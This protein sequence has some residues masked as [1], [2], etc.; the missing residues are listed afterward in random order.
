MISKIKDCK[1]FIE[2]DRVFTR[3]IYDVETEYGCYDIIIPKIPLN[4]KHDPRFIFK[5]YDTTLNLSLKEVTD[6]LTGNSDFSI[7]PKLISMILFTEKTKKNGVHQDANG[8]TLYIARKNNKRHRM[9]TK[10]IEKELGYMIEI[11]G[12]EEND[13]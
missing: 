1:T 3:L 7:P 5:N 4:F 9:T 11:V 12:E 6:R 2:N 10:E 13:I 8:K